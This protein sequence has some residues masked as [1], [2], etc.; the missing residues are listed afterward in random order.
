MG[1]LGI[2]AKRTRCSPPGPISAAHGTLKQKS[3]LVSPECVISS[4]GGSVADGHA[5]LQR[6]LLTG[7]RRFVQLGFYT[8]EFH[9][10]FDAVLLSTC[11]QCL[12]PCY[13]S[14]KTYGQINLR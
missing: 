4:G 9:S 5:E 14:K 6:T 1:T 8:P 11:C 10:L 12:Q 13:S 3:L 2:C 7:Q